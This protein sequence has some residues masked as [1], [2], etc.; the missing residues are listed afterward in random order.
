MQCPLRH[1]LQ[2]GS[3][4]TSM[5]PDGKCSDNCLSNFRMYPFGAQVDQCQR[6]EA[7]VP[8]VT[9]D[10]WEEFKITKVLTD[11]E[12]DSSSSSVIALGYHA[13][14]N[15]PVAIKC[16]YVTKPSYYNGALLY[17]TKVYQALRQLSKAVPNIISSIAVYDYELD[18]LK[19]NPSYLAALQRDPLLANL[20]KNLSLLLRSIW[21]DKIPPLKLYFSVTP[22]APGVNLGDYIESPLLINNASHHMQSIFFQLLFSLHAMFMMGFQH[23]DLHNGNIIIDSQ[24]NCTHAIYEVQGIRFSVP[25][26]VK[27][28]IYD[29]DW[30]SCSLCLTPNVN[31]TGNCS[32]IG[33]CNERNPHWDLYTALLITFKRLLTNPWNQV[34]NIMASVTNDADVVQIPAYISQEL[35]GLMLELN[36]MYEYKRHVAH[37]VH[38]FRLC[39]YDKAKKQC[40][41]FPIKEPYE[42]PTPAELLL[43]HFHSYMIV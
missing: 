35:F 13:K 1:P 2:N 10:V 36:R 38:P 20:Q 25:T 30:A 28:Y 6:P 32:I 27:V 7:P 19:R 39:N 42:L 34:S 37:E 8:T 18:D 14:S 15:Y 4:Q 16:F 22:L 41:P 33:A 9:S 24:P 26:P 12:K 43:T 40:G 5:C 23:N 31:L 11:K 17:E 21:P 29:F 3:P